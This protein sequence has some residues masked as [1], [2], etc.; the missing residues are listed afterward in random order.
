MPIQSHFSWGKFLKSAFAVLVVTLLCGSFAFAQ[1]P[2]TVDQLTSNT[3]SGDISHQMWRFI[4]GDF[5][6]NPWSALG[7][8]TTLIGGMFVTFNLGIFS[9]GMIMLSWGVGSSIVGT[10]QEGQALGQRINTAWYPVRVVTGVSGLVPVFSGFTGSQALI[11]WLGGLGIG[12]ANMMW[13]GAVNNDSSQQLINVGDPAINA[14]VAA[15][16]VANDLFATHVCMAYYKK[17]QDQAAANDV[18]FAAAETLLAPSSAGNSTQFLMKYGTPSKGVLCGSLSLTQADGVFGATTRGAT[19]GTGA[20]RAGGV[21]YSGISSGIFS[22]Y[23]ENASQLTTSVELIAYDWVRAREANL[24]S[25]VG[26]QT[27]YPAAAINDA[28]ARFQRSIN[29]AAAVAGGNKTNGIDAGVR[30]NMT[31]WGW[32]SAGAWFATFAEVNTSIAE[33]VKATKI[34]STGPVNG[35]QFPPSVVEALESV[36]KEFEQYSRAE[37]DSA[38]GDSGA[39]NNA[40]KDM[41]CGV[42]SVSSTMG[43]ATGNCSLGQAIVSRVIKISVNGVSRDSS[44]VMVA[45]APLINPIVMFKNMG[46]YLMT[47]GSTV[48]LGPSLVDMLPAGK[49][50]SLGETVVG[51]I[52]KIGDAAGSNNASTISKFVPDWLINGAWLILGLGALMSLYIPMIPFII[53][54]GAVVGYAASFLEGL[55]SGPL[56]SLSHLDTDGE[57]LG[58]RT[59]HGYLFMLNT[60]ARPSLMV[61]AFFIASGLMI[62]IG[63]FQAA[64]FLP[65]IA[66]A[67]GNSMTGLFSIIG[68]LLIFFVINVTLIN[69]C[70]EL[71]NIIPDQ[72]IGFVGAGSVN[73]SLGRD[74]ENKINGLYITA[75]RAGSSQL[76]GSVKAKRD[77]GSKA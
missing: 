22:T 45:G 25:G 42:D 13:N 27:P 17:A 36:A 18:P 32:I 34:V 6:D 8:P 41:G 60:I 20:F 15:R 55:I 46:D 37:A 74:T 63:T 14:P 43:T 77:P 31:Q 9:I 48:I 10:A 50:K 28:V 38:K 21:D 57:G 3:P 53:W 70:F 11:M 26:G 47:F 23:K 67:Q 35:G 16:K 65:A 44:N 61:I 75:V 76:A 30:A 66:N 62:V 51:G 49:L 71:I 33:A 2:L 19:S 56:H 7:Q 5:A 29:Q 4:F 72:V 12:L 39:I 73:T 69:A 1:S 59:S 64:L 40:M 54:M 68:Y 58:Q 24:A 52:S